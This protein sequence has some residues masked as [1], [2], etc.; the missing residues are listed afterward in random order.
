MVTT[1]YLILLLNRLDNE[2]VLKE[3]YCAG[4]ISDRVKTIRDVY[5][6]VD[7]E[8]KTK[9]SISKTIAVTRAAELFKCTEKTIWKYLS[10]VHRYTPPEQLV[11]QEQERS[12]SVI[13]AM[14]IC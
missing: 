1:P 11:K 10:E 9:S 3:L 13:A 6:F 8:L 2:G 4:L 5:L 12:M 7:A 14:H